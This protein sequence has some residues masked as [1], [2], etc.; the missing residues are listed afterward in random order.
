MATGYRIYKYDIKQVVDKVD[1]LLYS[2]AKRKRG[3]TLK[4]KV[5]HIIKIF[6][7]E[8]KSIVDGAIEKIILQESEVI[9]ALL[10]IDAGSDKW[11]AGAYFNF[12]EQKGMASFR[13]N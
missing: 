8:K 12:D 11:I 6:A 1:D 13:L 4:L 7:Q 2:L 9:D 3:K 10:A 5:G